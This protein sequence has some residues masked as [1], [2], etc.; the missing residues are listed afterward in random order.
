MYTAQYYIVEIAAALVGLSYPFMYQIINSLDIKYHSINIV[1]LFKSYWIS[2]A[3]NISLICL[4]ICVLVMPFVY[5]KDVKDDNLELLSFESLALA[6]L[7][8]TLIFMICRSI[9]LIVFMTI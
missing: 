4:M 9:I 6:V 2:T 1:R 5:E 8:I 3:Y 7:V